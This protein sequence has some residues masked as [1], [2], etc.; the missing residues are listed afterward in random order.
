MGLG[1]LPSQ[2]AGVSQ[3][4]GVLKHTHSTPACASSATAPTCLHAPGQHPA[5][6]C[7]ISPQPARIRCSC[8]VVGWDGGVFQQRIQGDQAPWLLPCST[9][10][11]AFCRPLHPGHFAFPTA[12]PPPWVWE[13]G[14]RKPRCVV[15]RQQ[16]DSAAWAACIGGAEV[17]DGGLQGGGKDHPGGSRNPLAATCWCCSSCCSAS[18]A[19]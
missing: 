17:V 2:W 10:A 8:K 14:K 3:G 15:A 5:Q 11:A 7:T 19:A 12:A 6:R 13:E 9:A 16:G 18:H 4:R 1:A